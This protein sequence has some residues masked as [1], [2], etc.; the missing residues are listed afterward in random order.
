MPSPNIGAAVRR[1]RDAIRRIRAMERDDIREIRAVLAETRADLIS[2]LASGNGTRWDLT[3]SASLLREV[4][5]AS[6]ALERSLGGVL[7]GTQREASALAVENTLATLRAQGI[8]PLPRGFGVVSPATL[9]AAQTV[10]VADMITGVTEEFRTATRRDLRRALAG[11]L[12]LRDFEKRVGRALPGPGPFGTVAKR[13]EIIVRNAW[14]EDGLL[15][16]EAPCCPDY[17]DSFEEG[18]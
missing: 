16:W 14:D 18:L 9:V 15:V 3:Y 11:G 6:E 5:A 10:A 4:D 1:A 13:A 8:E 12:D 2:R 17:V 7:L